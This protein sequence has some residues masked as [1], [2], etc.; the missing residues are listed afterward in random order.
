MRMGN[1]ETLRYLYRIASNNHNEFNEGVY[2]THFEFHHAFHNVSVY[3]ALNGYAKGP[4]HQ[5]HLSRQLPLLKPPDPWHGPLVGKIFQKFDEFSL[6]RNTIAIYFVSMAINSNHNIHIFYFSKRFNHF[7]YC[8]PCAQVPSV[9][10]SPSD[11][12]AIKPDDLQNV[13]GGPWR[14]SAHSA[15]VPC[16][17]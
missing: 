14:C 7:F 17:P 11:G 16:A 12:D 13:G 6:D 15:A 8:T 2:C 4:C 1:V 5:Q 10:T 3:P 9:V